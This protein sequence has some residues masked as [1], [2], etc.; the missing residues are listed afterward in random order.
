MLRYI[1]DSYASDI[2]LVITLG[3][4]GEQVKGFLIKNYPER[5][6]EFV[7][8]DIYEGP[9][10]SLGYSMLQAKR[11]LQCP[12]IFH[13]CD[14]IFMKKYRLRNIIGSEALLIIGVPLICHLGSISV[15]V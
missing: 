2:P 8:V 10:S 3:F 14:G 15:I 13:A 5:I 1:V 6:F 11:N 4:L 9:G 12:F 7:S